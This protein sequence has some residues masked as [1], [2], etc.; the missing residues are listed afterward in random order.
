MVHPDDVERVSEVLAPQDYIETIEPWN[1]TNTQLTLHRFAKTEGEDHLVLD[2][3]S[4]LD[5]RHREIVDA[6]T[7]Q[8]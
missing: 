2:I 7:D 3:L 5:I 1:F 8:R 6:A 4:G